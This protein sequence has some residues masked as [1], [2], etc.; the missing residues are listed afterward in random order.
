VALNPAGSPVD[1]ARC[2]PLG[3]FLELES[4]F[5]LNL[6]ETGS[7]CSGQETEGMLTLISPDGDAFNTTIAV[8]ATDAPL[9]QTQ[10]QRMALIAN[11]GLA[12]SIRP[13]HN[14]GDGDVVFGLATTPPAPRS[15]D[16][17]ALQEIYNAAADAL[18]RAVVHALLSH[19]AYCES[20]PEVCGP[21]G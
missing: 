7:I 12:R 2:I 19:G 18:G 17:R 10:A 11:S 21:R 8:V 9:D 3:H 5:G 1:P 14:L 20:Y 15:L 6:P 13:V 4:E 16:N